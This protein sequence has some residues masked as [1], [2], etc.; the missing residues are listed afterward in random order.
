M[1]V[2]ALIGLCRGGNICLIFGGRCLSPRRHRL[3]RR[4]SRSARVSPDERA[5]RHSFLHGLLEASAASHSTPN[6]NER[7]PP[8]PTTRMDG[9]QCPGHRI[10]LQSQLAGRP[11]SL[12]VSSKPAAV[13]RRATVTIPIPTSAQNALT[14]PPNVREYKDIYTQLSY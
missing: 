10:Y 8:P 13:R 12:V 9:V 5:R 4:Q 11:S 7:L 3:Q 14:T 1:H 6:S 2:A